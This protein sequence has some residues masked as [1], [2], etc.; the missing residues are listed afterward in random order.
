MHSHTLPAF[1]ALAFP[2]AAVVPQVRLISP[3]PPVPGAFSN[4]TQMSKSVKPNNKG[5]SINKNFNPNDMKSTETSM[6]CAALDP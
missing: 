2:A 6:K 4:I 1:A 5:T 3:C